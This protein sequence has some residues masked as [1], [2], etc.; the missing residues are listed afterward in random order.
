MPVR[1]K[2]NACQRSLTVPRGTEDDVI[3][4]I[5]QWGM[6]R[7]KPRHRKPLQGA[8]L[9]NET[10]R[11]DIEAIATHTFKCSKCGKPTLSLIIDESTMAQKE[12]LAT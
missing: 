12:G 1:I 9:L 2:C 7:W 4:Y 11:A 10:T 3:A 6:S 5:A 8:H